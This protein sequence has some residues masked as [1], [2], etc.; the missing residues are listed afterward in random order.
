MA[1]HEIAPAL[2]ATLRA[3]AE[4]LGDDERAIV[5]QLAHADTAELRL[6]WQRRR[7]EVL[8]ARLQRGRH[9][10]VQLWLPRDEAGCERCRGMNGKVVPV[11]TPAEDIVHADCPQLARRL[12]PLQV[13]G[14]IDQQLLKTPRPD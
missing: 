2:A 4:T 5:N 14:W 10:Q 12:C 11:G 7:V 8:L 13:S 6:F 1:A 3:V 9:H